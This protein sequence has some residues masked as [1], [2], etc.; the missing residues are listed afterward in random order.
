MN[1]IDKQVREEIKGLRTINSN[2]D[3]ARFE[4][5]FR[6]FLLKLLDFPDKFSPYIGSILRY[7]PGELGKLTSSLDTDTAMEK[8]LRLYE[9]GDA[10]IP[11]NT[12]S[13]MDRQRLL[14]NLFPDGLDDVKSVIMKKE[15]TPQQFDSIIHTFAYFKNL[16]QENENMKDIIVSH[17]RNQN[18]C[19]VTSDGPLA[20]SRTVKASKLKNLS[21]GGKLRI[22]EVTS[23]NSPRK[24]AFSALASSKDTRMDLH[25]SRMTNSSSRSSAYSSLST[26]R[27]EASKY[28][29]VIKNTPRVNSVIS[30]SALSSK[31]PSAKTQ[32]SASFGSVFIEPVSAFVTDKVDFNAIEKMTNDELRDFIEQREKMIESSNKIGDKY[33]LLIAERRMEIKSLHQEISELEQQLETARIK[34]DEAL[35]EIEAKKAENERIIDSSRSEV[36]KMLKVLKIAY[37]RNRKLKNELYAMEKKC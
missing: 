32:Q 22:P 19:K 13:D 20:I 7:L 26:P 28:S 5:V 14:L 36:N 34:R 9:E 15:L 8:L 27:S 10:P 1:Q 24:G 30:S 12:M 23:D 18:V 17:Y 6:F 31:H 3:Q 16:K 2:V 4:R 35:Q 11:S 37:D 33:Q 21:V 25:K 29:C